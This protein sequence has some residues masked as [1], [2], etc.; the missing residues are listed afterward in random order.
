[1][2]FK[3]IMTGML[4]AVMLTSSISAAAMADEK[5][6]IFIVGDSTACIYGSDD[7]YALPRAGWGMYLQNYINNTEAEVVDLAISG[8]SSKSLTVEEEYKT[9]LNEMSQ[10]DYLLIQ[11]GH[12]DAKK[13]KPE[14]LQN[15]YTDPE[16][17]KDTEGSFKNSLYKNY[18]KTAQEKGATPILLTPI[19]RRDFDENNNVK[20]THG[21]YDDDV[22]ELAA[23]LNVPLVDANKLTNDM[24]Q[25]LG[26]EGTAM[27][28]AIYKDV[29]KGDAGHDNTH[30]NHFGADKVAY[31]VAKELGNI[32][33]IGDLVTFKNGTSNTVTRA[34]FTYEMVRLIGQTYAERAENSFPDVD[35]LDIDTTAIST[36]KNLGIVTGDDK[37][38]F[39]PNK[40]INFQE[41]CTITARALSV[42]GAELNK[43]KAI[44]AKLN[45]S[46][47]LKPYAEESVAALMNLW[48]D[49]IPSYANP[50]EIMD[51]GSVYTLYSLVYDELNEADEN[52]APQ[53]IDEIEKVE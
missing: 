8:R 10:G 43:D 48:G 22:R 3:K 51:K 42:A 6:Q 49:V 38:N 18:I 21:I 23:E 4:S 33:G 17:D 44:L 53:S 27:Y 1:M 35:V 12:N 19:V 25:E 16:G 45:K 11:F 7:N 24:Y 39:N 30:L 5:T 15:R 32:N 50:R 13:T 34:E 2:L 29:K 52:T 40:A 47:E 46:D 14:D 28:H 37:G 31:A 9:L 41:M 26:L 20:D 36:A